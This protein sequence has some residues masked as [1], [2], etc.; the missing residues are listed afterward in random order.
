[1]RCDFC[2]IFTIGMD[3]LCYHVKFGSLLDSIQFDFY[4]VF[5]V[6]GLD[7]DY[8]FLSIDDEG[9]GVNGFQSVS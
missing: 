1:M 3:F 9:S 8:S 2:P 6:L 5:L 4:G 7:L